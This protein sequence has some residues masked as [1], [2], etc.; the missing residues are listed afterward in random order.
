MSPPVVQQPFYLSEE[1]F[2]APYGRNQPDQREGT[3]CAGDR[4][5]R[6]EEDPQGRRLLRGAARNPLLPEE[7][8]GPRRVRRA[9]GG[10]GGRHPPGADHF[11]PR[12]RRG[13]P[14]HPGPDVEEHLRELLVERY[15]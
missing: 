15:I 14:L 12:E 8:Q 4:G 5:Q 13:L 3:L 9:R 1:T 7:T 6:Q 10:V 2:P 11:L